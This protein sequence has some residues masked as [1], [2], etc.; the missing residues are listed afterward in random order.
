MKFGSHKESR[1][2]TGI[3][4]Q[5]QVSSEE[6][7]TVHLLIL[8][9]FAPFQW[10]W[11]TA[12][13]AKAQDQDPRLSLQPPHS[14]L[15][16]RDSD[17]ACAAQLISWHMHRHPFQAYEWNT[18][19]GTPIPRM[20]CLIPSLYSFRSGGGGGWWRGENRTK[21]NRGEFLLG[22]CCGEA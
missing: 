5:A 21:D 16:T 22:L 1:E 15:A 13:L 6:F 12:M 7:P 17:G 18:I 11:T 9:F 2:S 4:N 20:H 10:G 3:F 19:D 14:R 8:P